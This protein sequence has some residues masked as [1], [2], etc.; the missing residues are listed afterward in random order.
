[1]V[2]AETEF[3]GDTGERRA[4]LLEALARLS[5]EPIDV[6][7]LSHTFCDEELALFAADAR[8]SGFCGLILRVASLRS[9][10]GEERTVALRDEKVSFT[11]RQRTVLKHVC[12]GCSNRQIAQE[13]ACSEASVKAVLQDL[14][15]KLKVR[16]RAQIVRVALEMQ[17]I[18]AED[19]RDGR[20]LEILASLK[21]QSPLHVGDFV[22]DVAMHQ[23][24]LRGVEIHLTP[25][26]FQL[27]CIFALHAGTLVLSSTLRDM[28]WSNPTSRDGSLRVLVGAL[29]AKIEPSKTP[30]YLVTE[31]SL[32]YRFNPF[33]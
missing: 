15:K 29:R 14:F 1:M 23:V 3:P 26:E 31:R 17:A 30:R 16:K 24:W 2:G 20:R 28:F 5:S 12:Q 22:I 10:V 4:T 7:L 13:L 19:R 8:R 25:S 27:L 6:V 33:A 11:D 9:P 32:G 18:P 21:G